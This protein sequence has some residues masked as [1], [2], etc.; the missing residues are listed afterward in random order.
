VRASATGRFAD[1]TDATDSLTRDPARYVNDAGEIDTDAIQADLDDLL[2]R[3]PHWAVPAVPEPD[4]AAKAP[5]PKQQPKPDP[6]QGAR[7]TSP[8]TDFRT[9]DKATVD[10]EFAK[11]G[12][13]PRS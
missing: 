3:K 2:E 8:A 7:P 12:Y 11:L 4:P 5:K 13:R 9:A 10:A 1:P 6:G